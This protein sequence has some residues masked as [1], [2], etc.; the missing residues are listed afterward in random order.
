MK[1]VSLLGIIILLTV[2]SAIGQHKKALALEAFDK[3]QIDGNV[4]LY[5][6]Q[7]A[8]TI[9]GLEVKKEHYFYDYKIVVRHNT[10]Y[11]GLRDKHVNTA[12]KLK[13][14]LTHP[15]LKGIDMD[16]LVHV[17]SVDPVTGESFYIKGDGYIRGTVEVDVQKL[18]VD[19]D[20]FCSMSFSGKAD[21]SD[22]RLDGMGRINARGLETSEVY[23]RAE[24]LAS[25]KGP[26][27]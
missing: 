23:K 11:I 14:Y 22:F 25:I 18:R 24:G 17:N 26:M 13:V 2:S 21:I 20:G 8:E 1:K 3:V 10:L 16:G 4:R 9:V 12:P 5:L 27:Y 7:G 6:E 19:L 15:A